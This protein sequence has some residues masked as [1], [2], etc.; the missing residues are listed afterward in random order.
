MKT[1]LRQ[2]IIPVILSLVITA[3]AYYFIN[4]IPLMGIP[5]A[6]D[7]AYVEV[8]NSKLNI[9]ARKYADAKGIESAI[10]VTYFLKCKLGGSNQEKP[11]IQ[12]TFA[13][14]DGTLM[15]LSASEKTVCWKGKTL[16]VKGNSGK[17]FVKMA[18]GL[19]FDDV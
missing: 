15:S 3:T 1:I 18:E 8:S 12:I 13:L 7:I 19:F 14:K 5:E 16:A 2:F 6:K 17:R 9:D 4:G 10:S 11:A